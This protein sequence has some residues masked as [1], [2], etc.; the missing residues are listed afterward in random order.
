M[1]RYYDPATAQFLTV[2]PDVA[3][4][5]SP[6][7]YVAADPLNGA[8]PT[9]TTNV[10]S[11][12]SWGYITSGPYAGCEESV[13]GGE[14]LCPTGG[15]QLEPWGTTVPG[16]QLCLRYPFGGNNGNGGCEAPLS[17]SE[18]GIALGV[19]AILATAGTLAL[20]EA[21]VWLGAEGL[22][23]GAL[24]T[25]ADVG[26]RF[27][28]GEVEACVAVGLGTAGTVGGT[29]ALFG[30]GGTVLAVTTFSAGAAATVADIISAVVRAVTRRTAKKC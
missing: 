24:A 2:D 12:G 22:T 13:S 29:V 4:T 5:L 8:D 30:V 26:P 1:A 10:A 16:Y 11:S 21:G 17:T 3:T 20:P 15:G 7:G 27:A 14:P 18:A 23:A 9:G 28:N 25:G 19:V 6:Y